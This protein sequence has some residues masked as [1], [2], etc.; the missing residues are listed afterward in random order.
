MIEPRTER[1]IA[2]IVAADV[3]GYTRLMEQDEAGT[4]AALKGRRRTVVEPIVARNQGRIFKVNGD[5]VLMEFGSAVNAVQ[6]AIEIQR[7][8]ADANS[9]TPEDR[10]IVLRIGINLG[11]VMI[12]G[13]DVYGEGVNVAARLESIAEPGGILVSGSAHE[14]AR[15]KVQARFEDCGIRG[16]K[17]VAEPVQAYRVLDVPEVSVASIAPPSERPSVA[18]LPFANKSDDPGQEYFADGITE[19]ITTGLSRFR[20]L[21]VISPESIFTYKKRAATLRT[22]GRE[23]GVH[24]VVEGSVRR[25]GERVRVTVQLIEAESGKHLWDER[26]DRPMEDIFAVQDEVVQSIVANVAGRLDDAGSERAL[27][28]HPRTLSIYD[29]L[30]QGR[31]FLNRG[32]KDDILRA[33]DLFE[34]AIAAEPDN[35]RAYVGLAWTYAGETKSYWAAA[36]R[37]AARKAFDAA[38]KAVDLDTGDSEAHLA[39]AWGY[40]RS[41]SNFDLAASQVEN[42]ININPNDCGNYCFKSWLLT[43]AGETESGIACANEAL[44]RNPLQR[45]DCLYTVAVADYLAGRYEHALTVFSQVSPSLF[46]EVH[47]FMAACYAELGRDKD[48]RQEVEEFLRRA[49]QM[50][51]GSPAVTDDSWRAY[52]TRY[53]P[54]KNAAQL[55]GLLE[56]LR[57]AGLPARA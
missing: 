19:D 26:Y 46:L 31:H 30:L 49:E 5:G 13:R 21:L 9:D 35:A 14:F 28:K 54:F 52:W 29:L 32:S 11:D 43:C 57:K 33:R 1:R 12:D 41:N 27:R 39:L 15:N 34:R 25:A 40:F 18:V 4:L 42:A 56:S 2:A 45:N 7:G 55:E 10:H 22:V 50:D 16:L 38:Q 36:P 53:V 6:C 3:V 44:R 48:A 47:A 17:N 24:F 51:H 8:M 37:E 20:S 23:L